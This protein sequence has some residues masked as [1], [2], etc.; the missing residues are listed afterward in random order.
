SLLRLF[1]DQIQKGGPIRISDRRATRYFMS[2]PEAVHLILRAAAIGKGGETFVFDMGEPLNIYELAKTMTL[3]AGLKPER[4]L[5]FEFVGLG[6]AEKITEQLWEDWELPVPTETSRILVTQANPLSRGIL[7]KIRRMEAFIARGDR[8]GLL[9]YV[10]EIAPEF[11][12]ARKARIPHNTVPR[13]A[14]ART[15][16]AGVA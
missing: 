13:E 16:S 2:A 6:D 15:W 5:L 14:V 1:W 4:D 11:S 8:E 12:A 9:E 10:H 7:D 3:F